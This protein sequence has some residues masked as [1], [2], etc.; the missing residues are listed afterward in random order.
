MRRL[1]VVGSLAVLAVL[2]VAAAAPAVRAATAD[3][4]A[5]TDTAGDSGTAADV[6]TVKVTND[7]NGQYTFD[8]GF[9]TPYGDTANVALYLDTDLNPAT[10]SPND[11]GADYMLY[12][13]HASHSFWLVK[14]NGS[15]W[16]D[17]PS[18]ASAS[19]SIGAANASLTASINRSDLGDTG[20][21]NFYVLSYEGDGSAGHSDDA[22]DGT[23]M[24]QYKLKPAVTLALAGSKATVAKAGSQWTVAIV[25]KRSDT[26]G[27]VG[28][29]GT[30]VCDGSAGSMRLITLTHAFVSG[31]AGNGSAAVC[32]F[33]L[34]KTVKHKTIHGTVTVKFNGQTLMHTF[35][36]RVK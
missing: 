10:G 4:T 12:D 36:N 1:A 24:W 7:D 19:V 2:C 31:G 23:A 25:V 30:L 11:I 27:T 5:F 28:S 35:T 33:A 13:D 18:M 14:W 29:D 16:E 21:F 26:G 9:A 8:I 17:A 32:M 15:D 34:P 3:P 6:G 20:G 22:P